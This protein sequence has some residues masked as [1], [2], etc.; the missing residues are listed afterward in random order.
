MA[1]T[2]AEK[3]RARRYR[4]RH[5]EPTAMAC[6][7][8][9]EAVIVKACNKNKY[10]KRGG[11]ACPDCRNV[12]RSEAIKEVRSK[13]TPAERSAHAKFARS[14]LD[15]SAAVAKQW[16]TIK[17]DPGAFAAL[18]KRRAESAANR[19]QTYD[20]DTKNRI[21]SALVGSKGKVRSSVCDDLKQMLIDNN[22]YDGFISEEPFHGFIPDEVNH[23]LKI[24]IEV[25]GDLY[26][27]NPAK[28][29][30]P[31]QFISA[32]RRTVGEQWKR[33]E[34]RLACFK[35][36]GY[37]PLVVWEKEIRNSPSKAVER[38]NVLVNEMRLKYESN[39]RHSSTFL[40]ENDS[41]AI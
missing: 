22:L 37:T 6:K 25:F 14:R 15:G 12:I 3:D 32:I 4:E 31:Q 36:H 35:K 26:H 28:Y 30:D 8:C 41:P 40:P 5:S 24:I 20:D 17:N 11:V 10:I 19:W 18:Q 2:Q 7:R 21:I 33:D 27:C 1:C 16:D 13:Q 39:A 34:R 9:G 29:K 23:D 38:I